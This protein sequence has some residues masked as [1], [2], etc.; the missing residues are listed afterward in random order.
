MNRS[1][2]QLNIISAEK[3]LFNGEVTSIVIP[4]IAGKFGVK[5]SH[6]PLISPLQE[7]AIVYETEGKEESLE[8]KGGVVEVNNNVVTICVI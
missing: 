8:V 2:I 5:P 7:G 6:A 3:K 1:K 4:G